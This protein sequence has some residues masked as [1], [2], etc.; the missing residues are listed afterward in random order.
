MYM[1]A[2]GCQALAER[3][4]D[5]DAGAY[6]KAGFGDYSGFFC[7][8]SSLSCRTARA[9]CLQITRQSLAPDRFNAMPV[10]KKATEGNG[11]LRAT[12]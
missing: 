12:S 5:L 4:P 10:H 9:T 6:A 8:R 11:N 1:L 3:K 7:Q 2:R